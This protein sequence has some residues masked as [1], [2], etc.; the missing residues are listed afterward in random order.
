M[1]GAPG[2]GQQVS[3]IW[4][5]FAAK[6]QPAGDIAKGALTRRRSGSKQTAKC[7]LIL[8][9]VRCSLGYDLMNS[10]IKPKRKDRQMHFGGWIGYHGIAAIF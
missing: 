1:T 5:L 2:L 9:A 4:L 10:L 3:L 6:K 8:T 7:S